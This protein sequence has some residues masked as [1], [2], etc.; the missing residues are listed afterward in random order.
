MST[1]ELKKEAALQILAKTGISRSNYLPPALRLLWR[2]GFKT[3]P[4]HFANPGLVVIVSGGYFAITWGALMRV[5][6]YF[7]R[8]GQTPVFSNLLFTSITAGFF[9]GVGVAAYY[10]YSRRKH[11]LPKWDSLA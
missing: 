7:L 10:A 4:P 11:Q 9:F 5:L 3:P 2:L 1:F 6:D 8:E